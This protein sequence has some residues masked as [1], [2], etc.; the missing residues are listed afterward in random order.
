MS[1][2]RWL[3]AEGAPAGPLH[4]SPA[5]AARWLSRAAARP[6]SRPAPTSLVRMA[7]AGRYPLR[8]IERAELVAELGRLDVRSRS[9]RPW[10]RRARRTAELRDRRR[11]SLPHLTAHLNRSAP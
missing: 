8:S 4:R 6:R 11:R 3:T 9:A 5:T 10:V 2:Y 1:G 7:G